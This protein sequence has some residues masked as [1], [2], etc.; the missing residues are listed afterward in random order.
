MEE[1]HFQK[2]T[3]SKPGFLRGFSPAFLPDFELGV[4]KG[5]EKKFFLFFFFNLFILIGG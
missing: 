4:K 3:N 2:K 1:P 5:A